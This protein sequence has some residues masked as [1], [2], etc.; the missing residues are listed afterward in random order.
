MMI[1]GLSGYYLL[2]ARKMNGICQAGELR[3]SY[4]RPRDDN[5]QL[6]DFASSDLDQ[7]GRLRLSA[8]PLRGN[9]DFS[10]C[11]LN[12]KAISID[13]SGWATRL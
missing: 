11:N 6:L 9:G 4:A 8:N 12:R 10:G 2:S 3:N 5:D 7:A 1:Y 13:G